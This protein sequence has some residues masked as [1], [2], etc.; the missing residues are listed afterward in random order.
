MRRPTPPP[1]ISSNESA[2]VLEPR[3]SRALALAWLG[4]HAVLGAALWATAVPGWA[5]AAGFI[6][7]ILHAGAARPAAAP[8]FVWR[9]DGAVELEAE[10]YV[11]DATTT[12]TDAWVLLRLKGPAGRRREVVLARDQLDRVTWSRL[13]ARLRRNPG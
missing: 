13:Q 4:L 11:L 9:A 8:A 12:Y 10:A 1:P 3:A 7:L 6:A 2:L 5:K